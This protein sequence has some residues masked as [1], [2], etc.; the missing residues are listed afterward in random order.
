MWL[1]GRALN[2]RIIE[3]IK[4]INDRDLPTALR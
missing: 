4:V 1:D 3:V 2:R